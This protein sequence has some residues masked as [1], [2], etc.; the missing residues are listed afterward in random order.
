MPPSSL[1]SLSPDSPSE[2]KWKNRKWEGEGEEGSEDKSNTSYSFP[3]FSCVQCDLM[4]RGVRT[5]P[6]L[7]SSSAAVEGMHIHRLLVCS[8]HSDAHT[9]QQKGERWGGR[10]CLWLVCLW[11]TGVNFMLKEQRRDCSTSGQ[12][13]WWGIEQDSAGALSSFW[14]LILKVK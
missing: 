9:V 6:R 3:A 10:I 5:A 2:G 13:F 12:K 14:I 8:L 7:A 1:L 4:K 11:W